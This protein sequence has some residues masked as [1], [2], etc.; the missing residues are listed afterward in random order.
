MK[1][2]VAVHGEQAA[3]QP[4]LGSGLSGTTAG[5]ESN[6]GGRPSTRHAAGDR[7]LTCKK[8]GRGGRATAAHRRRGTSRFE[9]QTA[10]RTR[11]Q[12]HQ[13][14][15]PPPA[16]LPAIAGAGRAPPSSG[17][18]PPD[19]SAVEPLA[20]NLRPSPGPRF[21]DPPARARVREQDRHRPTMPLGL[22][23]VGNRPPPPHRSGE[24]SERGAR[25][26]SDPFLPCCAVPVRCGPAR[27]AQARAMDPGV[28]SSPWPVAHTC[29]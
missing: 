13:C 3:P 6:S 11:R 17:R 9:G 27:R 20:T 1:K 8:R 26:R 29:P 14:G 19:R 4:F 10:P 15:W 28:F 25:L 7:L 2:K 12:Q 21:P 24:A 18:W 5:S 23:R 22:R 16:S